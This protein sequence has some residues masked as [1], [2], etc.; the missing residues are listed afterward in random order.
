MQSIR[1]PLQSFVFLFLMVFAVHA[2]AVP[3][4]PV[5]GQV[6]LVLGTVQD[7]DQDGDVFEVS[8]ALCRLHI[9]DGFA[10]YGQS[11]HE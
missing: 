10:R 9:D 3:T 7:V 8:R 4:G 1:H 11:N 5:I 2:S 6:T